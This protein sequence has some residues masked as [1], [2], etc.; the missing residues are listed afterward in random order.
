MTV[1]RGWEVWPHKTM[2]A[3]PYEV[4]KGTSNMKKTSVRMPVGDILQ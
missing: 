4:K 2:L 1:L 3:I